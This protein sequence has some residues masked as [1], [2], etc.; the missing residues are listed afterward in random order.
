M[1]DLNKTFHTGHLT[2]DPELRYSA[3]GMAIARFSIAV[4]GI[5]DGDVNFFN[6]TAFKR[7]AEVVAE[8]CKSGKQVLVEGSLKISSFDGD[9]GKKKKKTEIIVTNFQMLGGKASE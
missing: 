3:D 2:R 8:Y 1:A 9:D 4:N 7:Q 6:C 5:K